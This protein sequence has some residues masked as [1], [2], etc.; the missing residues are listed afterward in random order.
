MAMPDKIGGKPNGKPGFSVTVI[1]ARPRGMPDKIGGEPG[2]RPDMMDEEPMGAEQAQDDAADEIIAALTSV[3]PQK[4]R[5]K[6]ALRA[7]VKACCSESDDSE[8]D[9]EEEGN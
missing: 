6:V 9:Y 1:S 4:N 7:F 8:G 2:A 5:L 3:K